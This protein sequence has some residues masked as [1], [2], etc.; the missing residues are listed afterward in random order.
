MYDLLPGST[1]PYG[2]KALTFPAAATAAGVGHL[3]PGGSKRPAINALLVGTLER[4]PSKFTDLIGEIVRLAIRKK[5]GGPVTREIVD[6]VNHLVSVIG[7][8]VP[9]LVEPAFLA[10]LPRGSGVVAQPADISTQRAAFLGLLPLPPRERGF[11]Y[12]KFLGGLF[13][14]CSLSPRGSFRLVGEQIDGSLELDA[15]PYLVEA[16]WQDTLVGVGDLL[17]FAGKVGGKASWT[18]GLFISHTGFSADGLSAFSRGRQ[19]NVICADGMDIYDILHGS[20]SLPN[21]L[22][23][24][25][26]RASETNEAFVRV[27]D[28]F[29]GHTFG[30]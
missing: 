27:R 8:R 29:P 24:K 7:F 3:W 21:V 23:A 12:E 2:T 1:G 19:V 9:D 17:A 26:R 30:S 11:A 6:R 28:L 5:N 13:E 20:V 15:N 22:R 18:R 16:K 14:T 4:A 25:A 10:S